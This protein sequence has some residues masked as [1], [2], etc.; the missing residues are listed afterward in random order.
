MPEIKGL[1]RI[2]KQWRD[3]SS[4]STPPARPAGPPKDSTQV[5]KKIE[6]VSAA[7]FT[8]FAHFDPAKI[9][10]SHYNVPNG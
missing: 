9:A 4:P 7:G 5:I 2:L 10:K 3:R 6:R 1:G 8:N